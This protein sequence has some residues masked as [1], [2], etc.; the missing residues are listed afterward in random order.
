MTRKW[1]DTGVAMMGSRHVLNIIYPAPDE[2]LLETPEALPTSEPGTP[3][4]E[5]TITAA[6]LPNIG[7]ASAA[8][9]ALLFAHSYNSSGSTRTCYY[10]TLLNGVSVSSSSTSVS[11]ARRF[12]INATNYY[13]CAVGDVIALKLWASGSG[14]ALEDHGLSVVATRLKLAGDKQKTLRGITYVTTQVPT[15]VMDGVSYVAGTSRVF[16][17]ASVTSLLTDASTLLDI[18]FMK[19]PYY[20]YQSSYGDAIQSVTTAGLSANKTVYGV[21]VPTTIVYYPGDD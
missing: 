17:T 5:Y 15:L 19:A 10:R 9:T 8:W 16:H 12:T 7:G 14:V 1:G 3:Q 20:S 4:I 13:D 6:H 21:Y 18:L 2:T 11:N